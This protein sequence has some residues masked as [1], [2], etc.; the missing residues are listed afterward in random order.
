MALTD[1]STKNNNPLKVKKLNNEF[2]VKTF[3]VFM[4]LLGLI[5]NWSLK[6]CLSLFKQS[7]YIFF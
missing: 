4:F 6:K 7:H 3:Q 2:S 5:E 1:F